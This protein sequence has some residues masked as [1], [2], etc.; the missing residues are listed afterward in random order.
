[1]V[2]AVSELSRLATFYNAGCYE[3]SLET[4]EGFA[5]CLKGVLNPEVNGE[6]LSQVRT[7]EGE[8]AY[9]ADGGSVDVAVSFAVEG[10]GSTLSFSLTETIPYGWRF[11]PVL[12]ETPGNLLVT[13]KPRQPGCLN[14]AW[15]TPPPP[16]AFKL[17]Y[18]LHVPRGGANHAAI[19]ETGTYNVGTLADG[20]FGPVVTVPRPDE[21]EVDSDGDGIADSVE[22]T[23]DLDDHGSKLP[24]SGQRRG[25]GC[26][27]STFRKQSV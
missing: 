9:P 11:E 24:G 20:V 22:G 3:M 25:R 2:I 17:R 5:P 13:P 10:K 8:G 6:A 14:F 26:P 19:V 27:E 16:L 15:V 21:A 7:V 18:R 1:M 4:P 12:G 23:E